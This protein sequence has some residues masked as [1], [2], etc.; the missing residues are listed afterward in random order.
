MSSYISELDVGVLVRVSSTLFSAQLT[1]SNKN[2]PLFGYHKE[3]EKKQNLQL[4][5]KQTKQTQVHFDP[6]TFLNIL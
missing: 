5:G 2:P 1:S 4:I 6:C 3:I